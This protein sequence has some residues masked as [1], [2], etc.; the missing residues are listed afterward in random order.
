MAYTTAEKV[1]KILPTLLWDEEDLGVIASGTSLALTRPAKDVP[2]ILKD[3]STLVKDTDF[4]F[5]QPKAITLSVAATGENFIAT[6]YYSISDTDLEAIIARADRRIDAYFGQ[7]DTPD[8]SS[9][10]DWSSS[11]TA[12]MYLREYATATEENLK[13][14]EAMEK[15]AL[16]DMK[17]YK[18]NQE[19]EQKARTNY[20]YVVKTRG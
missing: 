9:R 8:S 17:R 15:Q 19:P 14:A 6:C 2:T 12:A 1:R 11:L 20:T 5:V 4:T 3:S 13:R 18:D 16:D 7:H 10:E